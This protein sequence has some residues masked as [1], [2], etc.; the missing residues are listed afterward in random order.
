MVIVVIVVIIKETTI[1]HNRVVLLSDLISL[2]QV[3]RLIV[4]SIELNKCWDTTSKRKTATYSLVEAIFI[5]YW[6]HA[7][8][9]EIDVVNQ[10][11]G[12]SSVG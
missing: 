8:Y 4:L 9:S 2:R 3:R 5:E 7:R 12:L 1:D 10:S 6:K 11:I